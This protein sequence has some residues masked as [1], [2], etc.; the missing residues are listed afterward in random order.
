MKLFVYLAVIAFI[1]IGILEI[2]FIASIISAL[3]SGFGI[4]FIVIAIIV[5]IIL[6]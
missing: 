1:V 2:G 4:I 6:L 3:F 5:T